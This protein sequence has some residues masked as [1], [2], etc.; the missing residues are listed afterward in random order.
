M[1]F[2]LITPQNFLLALAFLFVCYE[3]YDRITKIVA[4]IN[5]EHDR[6]K[7]WDSMEAKL[8]RNIQEER[9]KIYNK[10]D[11]ELKDM[12]EDS[13]NN[14]TEVVSKIQ[15][16]SAMMIMLMRSVNAI[17]EREISQGAN[18]EVAKMHKELNNFLYEELGK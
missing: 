4:K 2:S 8:I 9:D 18:G 3:A 1:D 10:Y 6:I 13:D 11:N 17:L 5:A 7:K 16:Q 14:Y 12:R 15:Q